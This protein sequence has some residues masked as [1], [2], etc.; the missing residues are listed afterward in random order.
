M[1]LSTAWVLLTYVFM[2]KLLES[3]SSPLRVPTTLST[4]DDSA[5]NALRLFDPHVRLVS[6]RHLRK[7][8]VSIR[9]T[10]LMQLQWKLVE[11]PHELHVRLNRVVVPLN[12]CPLQLTLSRFYA[13]VELTAP[14]DGWVPTTDLSVFR[15]HLLLA[16]PQVALSRTLYVPLTALL[17]LLHWCLVHLRA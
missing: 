2:R 11:L 4:W 3:E 17:A 6:G 14:L 7:S 12:R 5:W 15:Q 16:R 9:C 10:M 13:D 8:P 1:L